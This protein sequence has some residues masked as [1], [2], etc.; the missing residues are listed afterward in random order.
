MKNIILSFFLISLLICCENLET[1]V[2]LDIPE[3]EAKLIV[4]SSLNSDTS[5]HVLVSHTVGAFENDLPVSVNDATVLLFENDIFIDSIVVD[6]SDPRYFNYF[7]NGRNFSDSILIYYYKSDIIPKISTKYSLKVKHPVYSEVNASTFLPN[8]VDLFDVQIDTIS[9]D[10]KLNLKFSFND[11]PFVDNFYGL[12]IYGNCSKEFEGMEYDFEGEIYFY[13]NDPSFPTDI[14]F[15]GYT[16]QGSEVLFSDALFNGL[17]KTIDL[18]VFEDDFIGI[19][20]C[21]TIFLEFSVFSDEAYEYYNSVDQFRENGSSGV[22]GG[23][24][25]PVY[26]NVENGEGVLI[27]VNTQKV[28][29]IY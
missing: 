4:N 3:H 21:D 23:E 8:D 9:Y 25:V 11:N 10:E 20:D 26:S 6:L 14:P 12:N 18:D 29:I 27:S 22:F 19:S 16:F 28:Y 5:I 1:V 24:V 13:S 17:E 15:D 2:D 7:D